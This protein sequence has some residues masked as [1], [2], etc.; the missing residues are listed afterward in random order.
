MTLFCHLIVRKS[1]VVI[2]ILYYI[3]SLPSLSRVKEV[4]FTLKD[5]KKKKNKLISNTKSNHYPERSCFLASRY[6]F[7]HT[8]NH[9]AISSTPNTRCQKMISLSSHTYKRKGHTLYSYYFLRLNNLSQACTLNP[10]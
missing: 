1:H 7:I 3:I 4:S 8:Y 6:G 5:K 2:N 9:G 10:S